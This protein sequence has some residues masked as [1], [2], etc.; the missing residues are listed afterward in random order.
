LPTI[1]RRS[2]SLA[3]LTSPAPTSAPAES[4]AAQAPDQ[5]NTGENHAALADE[6]SDDL[7][8]LAAL[9]MAQLGETSEVAPAEGAE[10]TS[11]ESAT[12]VRMEPIRAPAPE[13]V[14]ERADET[15]EETKEPE[16]AAATVPGAL[17]SASAK[18]DEIP[19]AFNLNTCTADDLVD[20]IAGC[21]PALAEAILRHRDKIGSYRA[22]ADLLDVPGMTKA[23]YINLTGEEPP[24]NRV[25]LSLNELLGFAP[26]H[27][28]SLK[29]VTDRISCWPDVTGCMLSQNSGLSLVG[30][31][32]T[33]MDKEAVV[34]F[35]P[36]MFEAI[37]KSFSELAGQETD[38]LLIP[39]PGT[40]YH[41]FR[42]RD[43]YLIILCRL[44][45][46]PERHMKVARLVL[47]AL[48]E[49]NG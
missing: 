49:R 40:S 38:A 35:A 20:H 21:T 43:L 8:R 29:D 44:P 9:A 4:A 16:T 19:V 41:L 28:A 13:P 30:T 46:M 48:S 11:E 23:A 26:D 18:T 14:Q 42:N 17:E 5:P 1:Q 10:A 36:R 3:S 6:N 7:Q 37:N 15:T 27:V 34:A 22:I 12:T 39:T 47:A 45:Q 2:G 24:A 31:V 33:G 32:P 25:Q